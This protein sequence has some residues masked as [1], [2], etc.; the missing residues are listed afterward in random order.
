MNGIFPRSK[1]IETY[2]FLSSKNIQQI[3]WSFDDLKRLKC[4]LGF[5]KMFLNNY[6]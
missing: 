3:K 5:E 4:I 1:T 2:A 6:T